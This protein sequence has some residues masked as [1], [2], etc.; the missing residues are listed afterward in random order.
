MKLHSAFNKFPLI[1]LLSLGLV[2]SPL[3]ASADNGDRGRQGHYQQD[4]GK[5]HHRA[6]HRRDYRDYQH[7]RRYDRRGGYRKHKKSH[8]VKSPIIHHGHSYNVPW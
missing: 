2:C 8:S 4:R 3:V 7:D 1:A 5:S 6:D